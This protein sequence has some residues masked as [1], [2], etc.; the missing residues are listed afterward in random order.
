LEIT[1]E[2]DTKDSDST[3]RGLQTVFK[4]GFCQ[5]CVFTSNYAD[6]FN[7]DRRDPLT[8]LLDPPVLSLHQSLI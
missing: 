2:D 7:I 8:S 6:I 1:N 3:N 5:N 4:K